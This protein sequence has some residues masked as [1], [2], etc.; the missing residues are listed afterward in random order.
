MA[1]LFTTTELYRN[2]S[3]SLYCEDTMEMESNLS[4][5][6]ADELKKCKFNISVYS[7]C[8]AICLCR[9]KEKTVRELQVTITLRRSPNIKQH[10]ATCSWFHR[11][12][13]ISTRSDLQFH[14]PHHSHTLEIPL[15]CFWSCPHSAVYRWATFCSRTRRYHDRSEMWLWCELVE[16]GV[17]CKNS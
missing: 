8:D 16:E 5:G 9:C 12:A 6:W 15:N 2:S 3:S 11:N 7:F 4:I 10:F 17:L 1:C 14:V 13:D